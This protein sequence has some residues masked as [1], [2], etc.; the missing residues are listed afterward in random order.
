MSLFASGLKKFGQSTIKSN[1]VRNKRRRRRRSRKNRM[2][3]QKKALSNNL[4]SK[5]EIQLILSDFII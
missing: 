5:I 2:K 4:K 1:S 3:I